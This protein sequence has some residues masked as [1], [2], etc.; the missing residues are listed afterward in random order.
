MQP[1]KTSEYAIKL[2]DHFISFIQHLDN[3]L[4]GKQKL[5]PEDD[6]GRQ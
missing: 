2:V 4:E 5:V 6:A 1:P 3:F